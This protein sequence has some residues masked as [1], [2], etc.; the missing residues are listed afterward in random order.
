MADV[1]RP[2]VSNVEVEWQFDAIDLRPVER[3][4]AAQSS[5]AASTF[6][7][8]PHGGPERRI[9]ST[10]TELGIG[11]GTGTGTGTEPAQHGPGLRPRDSLSSSSGTLVVSPKPTK[12]LVDTY[13]DT[14]DWR[15]CRAGYVLRLRRA[16][17]GAEMTLKDRTPSDSGLRKRVEITQALPEN[18]DAQSVD[19]EGAVGR[20]IRA[21]AGVRVL[22]VVLEVRTTR[23]PFDLK[24]DQ[25]AVAELALDETVISSGDGQRPTRLRRVEIEVLPSWA[26][27]LEPVVERLRI[28][29]GL[30]PATLSKFE[31][32]LLAAGLEVPGPP[33]LG[34]TQLPRSPSVGDVAYVVLRRNLASMLAHEP[35][36]RLGE[37]A[38]E[39]HDMRVATRRMRAALSLFSDALPVRAHHVRDELGWLGR[40]LG[41]VR[42][43]DVQLERLDQWARDL[44]EEDKG[45]LDELARLLERERDEARSQLLSA[46]DSARYERLLTSYTAMLRQGPSRRSA[47]ARAPAVAVVPDLVQAR[48]RSATKA[49][50]RAQRSRAADDF[51]LLRIRCKR[52]RYALEFVSEIYDGETA[53]MVRRVVRLQD[54]LGLMQDARVAAERLKVLATKETTEL[55]RT[56]IFVMGGVAQRHRQDAERVRRD[57]PR[58]LEDLKG[59]SWQKL[60]I[61]MERKRFEFGSLYGWPL[62]ARPAHVASASTAGGSAPAFGGS[63]GVGSDPG[64]TTHPGRGET[65][66]PSEGNGPDNRS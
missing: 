50:K 7:V 48:H 14:E 18:A 1:T 56:T 38:E 28:T 10:S 55:S 36:T 22:R 12:R 51:H 39:L 40:T 63:Q 30:Q 65:F 5:P 23:R 61:L 66:A 42:D 24:I 46:L 17:A 35:G 41:S 19:T 20:R 32:G 29:C 26:E 15:V 60:K 44:P 33:D 58:H 49:A 25:Q 9:G 53:K 6:A 52:L 3:W 43:L 37:D 34:A 57:V 11:V 54:S 8:S 13:L 62:Q 31:A 4:I 2:A 59:P 47:A 64:P 16:G 45:A 21:L 27:V